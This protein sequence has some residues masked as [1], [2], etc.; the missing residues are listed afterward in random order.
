[1]FQTNGNEDFLIGYSDD[2]WAG[3]INT[4]RSTSGYVFQI[5][6]STISWCSKRQLSISTS[7]TEA[8]YIALSSATQEDVWLRRLLENIGLK[9]KKP[10]LI[11]EN[12]QGA[13]E[14][15]KNPKFHNRT[16]HID[17]SFHFI[18]EKVNSKVIKVSYCPTEKTLA[19]IMTKALT[20]AKFEELP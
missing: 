13:I 11:Y 17:V 15:S 6:G 4:R 10:S 9:Q 3:D 18:R 5:H 16:K 2:D 20:K 14:L 8:K 7:S 1:M 19:D 12:N